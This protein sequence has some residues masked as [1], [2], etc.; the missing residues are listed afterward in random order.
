MLGRLI[1]R[2][3]LFAFELKHPWSLPKAVMSRPSRAK[4]SERE[5]G[6]PTSPPVRLLKRRAGAAAGRGFAF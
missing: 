4:T 3:R 2:C 6:K 1:P 5:R